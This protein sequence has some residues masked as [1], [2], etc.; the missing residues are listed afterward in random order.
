MHAGGRG[1]PPR[2]R[3]EPVKA[4]AAGPLTSPAQAEEPDSSQLLVEPR[5]RTEVV[6]QSVV[7]VMA[8]E[9]ARTPAMLICKGFV[10]ALPRLL[11]NLFQLAC[12]A[13]ACVL[14]FTMYR[15]SRVQPR[16]WVNPRNA[17]VRGR[18][19]RLADAGEL[20]DSQTPPVGS[21]PQ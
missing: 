1:E 19:D 8:T 4:G 15:P 13:P 20:A 10:H 21:S 3:V 9:H 17:K 2:H 11:A 6:G 5:E 16:W 18:V 7:G 14:C 12:D